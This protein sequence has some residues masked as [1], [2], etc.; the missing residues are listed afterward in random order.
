MSNGYGIDFY[1]TV[2]YGYSQPVDYS[3]APFTATQTDYERLTLNWASPNTTAWKSLLLVRSLYGYPS[4]P[5]DGTAVLTIVPQAVRRNF[6][7][8]GL[9]PGRIY[10]YTMF[11]SVEAPT[12][13]GATTYSLTQV[14]LYNGLYWKSLQNSNT[15]NTPAVGSS[16][17]ANVQYTPVWAPAG[18]TASLAVASYGYGELLY[19][20]IPN[21]YKVSNSDVFANTAIDNLPLQQYMNVFGWGLDMTR[22]EYD[23]YLQLNNPD[24]VSATS[25]DILGQQLGSKTDY[26]SSPQERRQKVKN[27]S[28]N[29]HLKGTDISIH[30]AIASISGW[31]STVISSPNI[32]INTDQ[33]QFTHPAYDQW[34][35]NIQYQVN[36]LVQFN[37]YDYTCLVAALGI[38]EQPTGTSS[39][40]TWWQAI[41]ST[42]AAP[43]LDT[44]RTLANPVSNYTTGVGYGGFSTWATAYDSNGQ[45]VQ[46]GVYIG[47]PH[48]TNSAIQN[49]NALGY[50]ST[51][52]S[53][54]IDA[55]NYTINVPFTPTWT[56]STNYVVNNWVTT[57]FRLYWIAL[58]PS[59]PGTPYGF[60]TPGSN[61][62]FWKQTIVP[63]GLNPVNFLADSPAMVLLPQWNSSTTFKKGTQ[64]QY[65]GII[66]QAIADNTNSV[67]SGYYY[68]NA[69]WIY[70]KPAEYTFIMSAYTA[71]LT[72]STTPNNTYWNMR[73]IYNRSNFEATET[74]FNV[75]SA[76][77]STSV[78]VRFD[79][80]YADLNGV[81]DNTLSSL[82]SAWVATPGTADLWFSSY[83]MA[84]VNQSLFGSTTYVYLL[85]NDNQS[86][87]D[88]N[89]GITY[90]TDY[91]DTAHK[92]NGIIFRYQ[93]ANNFW[94]TTRKTLY[95]VLAG[96]ETVQATWTRLNNGDRMYIEAVGAQINVNKYIR[97]G[98]GNVTLLASIN[99]SNMQTQTIHGLIQKYSPSG[100]V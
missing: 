25:L 50:E 23:S 5:N 7:D 16:F 27:L 93:N 9:L 74:D 18:H 47:L 40:N 60:I 100:A 36:A 80:D 83:G 44:A 53:S 42:T 63:V 78:L 10:Y 43:V 58:K 66:Y 59:G 2:T 96:V 12:Y 72:T 32:L 33:A 71:R 39:N 38:A 22:T 97:D 46:P 84:A 1:G 91:I 99:D 85:M 55:L 11:L 67:P 54:V 94:Y 88:V 51:I 76:P 69:D 90:V 26:L 20:R 82:T 3:V 15:G 81:N 61:S 89:L 30:N 13:S 68:S 41:V 75:G 48:P 29:Y 19:N 31:D 86:R 70:I 87:S 64:V 62:Q 65:F 45:V 52:S 49:W 28:V 8:S 57:G 79:G 95:R 56:N 98:S 17:W 77:D 6:D 92:G 73:F 24:V 34:N 35:A 4:T 21:P 37:G 14:V